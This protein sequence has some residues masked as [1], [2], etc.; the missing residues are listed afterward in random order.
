MLEGEQ[1]RVAVRALSE[2]RSE[3]AP[4]LSALV[5]VLQEKGLDDETR[6]NAARTLGKLG[7]QGVD[8][9]PVLV[10]AL[11]DE[12]A[13]VREHAAE[14]LGDIGPPAAV[15]ISD[16][17]G[18]LNDPAVRVR[19]DA[20]RSLGQIG[21]A[22]RT[23]VSAMKPLLDDPEKIV[24]DAARNALLEIAPEEVPPE[25]ESEAVTDPNGDTAGN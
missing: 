6:W 7:E 5:R 2:Y 13:T 25:K 4:A 21:Q 11:S 18:V 16:L 19:R 15:A 14:A 20:V 3:A 1:K 24:R 23:A 9:I 22:A 17:V 8:A 12:V 10:E